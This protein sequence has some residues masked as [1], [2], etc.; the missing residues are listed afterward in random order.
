MPIYEQSFR[1]YEGPR[2]NRNHWWPVAWMTMRPVFKSKFIFLFLGYLLVLLVV[3]SVA[4]FA[5]AWSGQQGDETQKALKVALMGMKLSIN[6]M[7][8][9][10]LDF[11]FLALLVLILTKGSGCISMDL[12]NNALPLYF[13]RPL[14]PRDYLVGKVVGL[15]GVPAVC[16]G[17][18]VVILFGQAAAYFMTPA[19]VF[20]ELPML[21]G[22]LL[23]VL[24]LSLLGAAAMAAASS[25]TKAARTASSLFIGYWMLAGFAAQALARAT[26]RPELAAL[27]P[28]RSWQNFTITILGADPAELR[29]GA[30][31]LILFGTGPAVLSMALFILF[32]LWVARRNLKVVEVVK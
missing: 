20:A 14:T 17:L 18:G 19:Q 31:D 25:L 6:T 12:Q 8:F 7:L 16:L 13:S 30:R 26:R 9:L 3:F 21:F 24:V 32:F 4:M 2:S 27:S 28:R 11:S 15:A 29:R 1:H 22:A 5:M 10:F 23:S